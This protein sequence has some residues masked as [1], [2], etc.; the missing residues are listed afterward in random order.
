MK[1]SKEQLVQVCNVAA[2][3]VRGHEVPT[4]Q[5]LEAAVVAVMGVTGKKTRRQVEQARRQIFMELLEA[6][7]A[8][9]S[10]FCPGVLRKLASFIDNRTDCR[11]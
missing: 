2:D 3:L 10:T 5:A 11:S 8:E 4:E 7:G 6:Y 9:T 1:L